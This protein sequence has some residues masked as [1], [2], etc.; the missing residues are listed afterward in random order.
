MHTGYGL[1]PKVTHC[2]EDEDWGKVGAKKKVF[3][4]KSLTQKGGYA[5]DDTV[6]ERRE[7]EYWKIKVDNFQSWM[8]GFYK[9]EGEWETTE[10][11]EN[12]VRIDYTYTLYSKAPLLY[13]L[14][15]LFTKLFWR[16][17][18]MQVVE[19]IRVMAEGDEAFLYD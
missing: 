12:V 7:N 19:N 18:M 1:M 10:V 5:S 4:S 11:E 6:L 13:P 16:R 9:F 14:N 3:A 8:L 17:Y 2:T 15:W